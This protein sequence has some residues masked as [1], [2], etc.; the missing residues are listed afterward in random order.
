MPSIIGNV[1]DSSV[2]LG[3]K[4]PFLEITYPIPVVLDNHENHETRPT[5]SDTIKEGLN[6]YEDIVHISTTT[7]N[8]EYIT[9]DEMDEL[10][11]ILKGGIILNGSS[12]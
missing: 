9:S 3:N 6:F 11:S 7:N 8:G 12:S 4:V 5:I 2:V 1:S 10:I